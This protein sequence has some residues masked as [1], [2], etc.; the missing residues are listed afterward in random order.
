MKFNTVLGLLLIFVLFNSCKFESQKSDKF[1]FNI[2]FTNSSYNG[3]D[4][5]YVRLSVSDLSEPNLVKMDNNFIQHIIETKDKWAYYWF[6]TD[7]NHKIKYKGGFFEEVVYLDK[8][9]LILNQKRDSIGFADQVAIYDLIKNKYIIEPSTIVLWPPKEIIKKQSN[10][11]R[12]L[13]VKNWEQ[14]KYTEENGNVF[15]DII[16]CDYLIFDVN[17]HT[18]KVEKE[19]I[20]FEWKHN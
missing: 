14:N 9:I 11:Y 15:I 19:N 2:P 12:I 8:N 18:L 5:M 1:A 7:D 16:K 20:E 4:S 6:I 17:S 3:K 10:S 13:K